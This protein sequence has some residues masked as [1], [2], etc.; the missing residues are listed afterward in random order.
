MTVVTKH[1]CP[2][3][4]GGMHRYL[5]ESKVVYVLHPRCTH[6]GFIDVEIDLEALREEERRAKAL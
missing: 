2:V 3:E 6:C 5:K 1:Y 4:P